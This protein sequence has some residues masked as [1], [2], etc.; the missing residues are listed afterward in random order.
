MASSPRSN[1]GAPRWLDERE[2]RGWR[3]LLALRDGLS[4]ALER[5]LQRDSG[6][7]LADYGVLV[8]LSEAPDERLR[9]Y[10][11]GAAIDWE[12]SRLSH[13][14]SRMVSRGLVARERCPED[15]RGGY[16][17]LTDQ[18]RA[19]IRAAAPQHVAEVRRLFIDRIA[20]HH[21]DA[22]IEMEA[23]VL[24]DLEAEG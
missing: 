17:V 7:S 10:E 8:H 23:L 1:D 6:L 21:L 12:K 15:S 4:R 24:R 2:Q 11:L 5:Q 20:P 19:V 13:H 3:A 18:G 9:H 22:L 16:V 14:L